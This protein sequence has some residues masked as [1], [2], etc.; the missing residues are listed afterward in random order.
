MTVLSVVDF[1]FQGDKYGRKQALANS[2]LLMAFP[3]TI[4]GCLPTY[5]TAG[6]VSLVLL[7]ICR[8]IQGMS[9][10]GQ[11]PASLVYTVEKRDPSQWGFYGCLP[12]VAAQ[13]GALL[14]N[15][16][17]ALMRS[18]LTEEELVAWG[19]RIPFLSGIIIG[20]VAIYIK[21]CGAELDTHSNAYND[22][23]VESPIRAAF[24][25]ENRVALL[26][27]ML[28][29][30]LYACGFYITY[31]WMAIFME[32]LLEPA[33]PHA[34]WVNA[35]SMLLGLSLMMPVAGWMSDK[36]GSRI[37]LM[38]PACI[39]MSISGPLLVM[40]IAKSNPWL[41]FLAQVLLGAQLAM[42]TGPLLAWMVENFSPEV[43]MTSA[44][45]G[46]DLAHMVIAGF[47]PA[48]A[49]SLYIRYG[50]N[51]PGFIYT[52]FGIISIVGIYINHF[53][54]SKRCGDSDVRGLE[55]QPA[56]DGSKKLLEVS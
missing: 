35:G 38:A 50:V 26:S 31:V 43:R 47:S 39:S 40:L 8:L 27:T 7:V 36:V 3:T 20:F 37:K 1:I 12:V 23:K 17:G 32:D 6:A 46:Y 34:F 48:M 11:L 42:Y 5:E 56:K 24:S 45:I 30:S 15:L 13:I 53:Y 52:V 33:V 9:T 51:A 49:T 21:V 4:M 16:T 55:L 29:P 10:G 18:L 41:A 19:W 28:T 54:G 22:R 2:L 25:K 44:A 14:G